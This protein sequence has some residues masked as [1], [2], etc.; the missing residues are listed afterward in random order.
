[1]TANVNAMVRAGVEAYRAGNKIEARTLLERAI[2]LDEQNEQAWLWLSAVVDNSDEQIICLQNVLIINPA[3]DRARQGLRSLGVDPD[4]TAPPPE[5]DF[6][7]APA[8][9]AGTYDDYSVPSSSVSVQNADNDLSPDDYDNWVDNLNIGSGDDD[10]SVAAD[11]F[12][13]DDADIF[14]DVDFSGGDDLFGDA[15]AGDYPADTTADYYDEPAAAEAD[16]FGG[17]DVFTDDY[18]TVFNS[19]DAEADALLDD[20]LLDDDLLLNDSAS[21][22]DDD[23]LG[24]DDDLLDDDYGYDSG[25]VEPVGAENDLRAIFAEY[26]AKIPQDIQ[27]TRLPGTDEPVPGSARAITTVLA[28]MN[29]G[30]LGFIAFAALQMMQ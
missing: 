5:E 16:P 26:A 29:L 27:P 12:G 30:A 24:D 4:A 9:A 7:S 8:F 14:G 3:N 19:D 28:V 11:P 20:D 1:M 21:S 15:F 22:Y 17:D 2:E 18:A 6:S 13:G 23:L 10:A 25:F